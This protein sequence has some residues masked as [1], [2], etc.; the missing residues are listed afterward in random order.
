MLVHCHAGKDRTGVVVAV[1]LAL[2]GVPKETIVADYALSQQVLWPRWEADR[3]DAPTLPPPYA[4]PE[5]MEEVLGWLEREHGGAQGY[6]RAIGLSDDQIGRLRER[7]LD[8]SGPRTSSLNRRAARRTGG[9]GTGRDRPP[10]E[11]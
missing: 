11:Q 9:P 2:A 8:Q 1:L 3:L 7:L 4:P 10:G 5:A 6:L